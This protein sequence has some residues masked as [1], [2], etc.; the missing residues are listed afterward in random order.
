MMLG[1]SIALCYS[2]TL[3]QL[4]ILIDFIIIILT[5]PTYLDSGLDFDA[6]LPI[7]Q[8]SRVKKLQ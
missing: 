4:K 1:E 8:L 2:H 7:A 5:P 3:L 6:I